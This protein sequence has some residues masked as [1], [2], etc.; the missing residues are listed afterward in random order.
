MN[1][2]GTMSRGGF[3][4]SGS[5]A[6]PASPAAARRR[7][8]RPAAVPSLSGSGPR[9]GSRAD[10]A[11][12]LHEAEQAIEVHGFDHGVE[13]AHGDGAFDGRAVGGEDDHGDRRKR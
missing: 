7:A 12:L 8:L 3:V 10:S 11:V 4:L 1:R 13:D 2:P 6:A 9:H 5:F